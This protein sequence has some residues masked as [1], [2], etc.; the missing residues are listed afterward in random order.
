MEETNDLVAK[1]F[2]A[3][4]DVAADIINVL[5]YH[6]EET[7][8]P[9]QLLAAPTES[10]YQGKEALRNQFEDLGRYEVF[11]GKVNTLYLF[12]NQ[13]TVDRGMLLRK[14]GYTGA[15]YREQYDGKMSDTYPVIELVLYWGEERWDKN[16][17]MRQMFR[18]KDLPEKAWEYIDNLKLHV[19]EMRYL[20]P[21]I[22]GQFTSDMRI[23]ADYLAEG[24]GY[25]SNRKVIHKEALI[26]MIRVLSGEKDVDDTA[27]MLAKMEIKEEDEIM[28]CELFDQ[29]IRQGRN[30]GIQQG[31][32]EGIQ[33]GRSEGIRQG[34][35]EGIQQGLKALIVTCKELGA[36]FNE[37]A[38]KVKIR[39]DL[40]EKEVQENMSL[41]W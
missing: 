25:R 41:Y 15:A 5:L 32:S 30:E 24:N 8:R 11:G 26:K 27:T 1:D 13:T 40:N 35:N 16:R 18:E 7:V 39:F 21:E 28:M 9:G 12:A 20:P 31:R 37:T 10:I 33:Q 2:E 38:E 29:Y 3:Y 34:R 17:S 6:G 19:F 4:P 14:A 23:V 36:N 22:R